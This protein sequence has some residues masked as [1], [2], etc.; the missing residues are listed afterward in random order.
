[1]RAAGRFYPQSQ[2]APAR[3][4]AGGD[5]LQ[6]VLPPHGSGLLDL[7]SAVHFVSWQAASA[8]TGQAGGGG[9]SVAFDVGQKC[10]GEHAE[11]SIERFGVSLSRG[12]APAV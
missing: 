2:A 7:D 5:P 10:R 11:P 8:R 4:G 6:T 3:A 12:V 9:I 1:M